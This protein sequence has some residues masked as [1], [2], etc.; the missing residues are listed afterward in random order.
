MN[1]TQKIDY[2]LKMINFQPID[3]DKS[4]LYHYI[5]W[6][7]YKVQLPIV[8]DYRVNNPKYFKLLLNDVKPKLELCDKYNGLI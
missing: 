3:E 8:N 1:I 5:A 2:A 7:H 4:L 6:E